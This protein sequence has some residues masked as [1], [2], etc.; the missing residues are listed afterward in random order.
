[1]PGARVLGDDSDARPNS[2][3]AGGIDGICNDDSAPCMNPEK[4]FDVPSVMIST[5]TAMV[6]VNAPLKAPS[7]AEIPI[8][9]TSG[10]QRPPSQ[11]QS[12]SMRVVA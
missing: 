12:T 7:T 4:T 6:A 9:S 1:M 11:P 5:G 2:A 3:I 10:S 8:T